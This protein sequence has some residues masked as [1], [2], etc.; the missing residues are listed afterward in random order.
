MLDKGCFPNNS[1]YYTLIEGLFGSKNLDG[2]RNIL[3]K[4]LLEAADIT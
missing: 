4:V 2:G 3:D 1:T